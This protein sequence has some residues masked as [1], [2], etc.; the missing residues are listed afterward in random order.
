MKNVA[1]EISVHLRPIFSASGPAAYGAEILLFITI[2]CYDKS[3]EIR[4]HAA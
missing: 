3:K 2:F 4:M 1:L